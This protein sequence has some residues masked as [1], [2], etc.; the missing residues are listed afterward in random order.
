M[1]FHTPWKTLLLILLPGLL[2]LADDPNSISL[3]QFQEEDPLA[4]FSIALSGETDGNLPTSSWTPDESENLYLA[5]SEA[6][7]VPCAGSPSQNQGQQSANSSKRRKIKRSDHR[8]RDGA[9]PPDFCRADAIR[10][11]RSGEAGQQVEEGQKIT[12]GTELQEFPLPD[13]PFFKIRQYNNIYVCHLVSFAGSLQTSTPVTW[14]EPCR[15]CKFTQ[16]SLTRD[17]YRFN[18]S[19]RLIELGNIGSTTSSCTAQED[20]WLCTY[21]L[22]RV[23]DGNPAVSNIGPRNSPLA[24]S[25]LIHSTMTLL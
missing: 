16:A 5:N 11:T 20:L 23:P 25:L 13:S 4:G 3:L 18:S 6:E 14:L 24:K 2:I 17:M 1:S 12:P 21:V 15:R 7:G 19:S 22:D 8:K 9:N 10:K